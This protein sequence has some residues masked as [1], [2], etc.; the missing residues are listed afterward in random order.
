MSLKTVRRRSISEI[1]DTLAGA[2]SLEFLDLSR[3]RVWGNLSAAC[4]LAKSGYVEQLSLAANNL[5]GGIPACLLAL[6]NL[7]ELRLDG[8]ALQGSIP[9]FANAK[10]C[11][12]VRFTAANQVC[13]LLSTR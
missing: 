13:F 10:S 2:A 6:K 11:K 12:L 3:N 9:A 5:T 4:G 7:V 8:N 1:A